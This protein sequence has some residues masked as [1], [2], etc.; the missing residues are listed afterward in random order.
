M[1]KTLFPFIANIVAIE[2]DVVV[3]PTPP[4]P[5]TNIHLNYEF[6]KFF[7]DPSNYIYIIAK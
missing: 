4:F 3:F 5:P 6:N 2:E 7:K 1:I